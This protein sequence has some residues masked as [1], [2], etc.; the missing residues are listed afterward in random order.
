MN[1]KVL[2][3]RDMTHKRKK[4]LKVIRAFY[5]IVQALKSNSYG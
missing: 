2:S 4:N 1:H 3:I 5:L